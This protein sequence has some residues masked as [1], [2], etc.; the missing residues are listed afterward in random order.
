MQSWAN[1]VADDSVR[2][3][4]YLY[5]A[6]SYILQP[7]N[8]LVTHSGNVLNTYTGFQNGL[9]YNSLR[10]FD[11]TTFNPST[12]ESMNKPPYKL[13]EDSFFEIKDPPPLNGWDAR[14]RAWYQ[15]GMKNKKTDA[16]GL[17]R[18]FTDVFTG[19]MSVAFFHYFKLEPAAGSS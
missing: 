7:N 11:T 5:S 17:S 1:V 12:D 3:G 6:L 15:D 10:Y 16:V 13:C 8:K 4:L 2:E 14:C 18:P 9:F 19:T